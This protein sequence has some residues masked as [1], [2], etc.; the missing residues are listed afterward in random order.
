VIIK[1]DR[2]GGA[3]QLVDHLLNRDTNE[4][5]Q[6]REIENYPAQQLD[7]QNLR[8]ALRLMEVQGNA[9]GRKRTLYH[10]IIA[11]QQGETLNAKQMK[12]A[13][14]TL[15]DNLGLSGH[16]RVIIEHRK[17]G[18]QHF[19]VV[20]NIVNPATGKLARLQ[21]TRKIQWNTARQLEQ[22]LG[23][24]PVIAR[25][26]A[27]RQW[28]HQRGK[29]SGIDPLKVRKEI[30][31]ICRASKTGSEFVAALDH[32]GYVLT[33]GKN[34][35]YVLVDRAGDIH[36][37]M[38]RIEGAKLKDLRQKFPDLRDIRLPFL[39]AT[40]KNV[41]SG[42][43]GGKSHS[44]FTK[45]KQ[46]QAFRGAARGSLSRNSQA[47]GD[48]FLN[49]YRNRG[50]AGI[51]A[52]G[53]ITNNAIRYK[54][55]VFRTDASPSTGSKPTNRHPLTG[56][57]RKKRLNKNAAAAGGKNILPKISKSP[58]LA[59]AHAAQWQELSARYAARRLGA[60]NE[61]DEATRDAILAAIDRQEVAEQAAL[62]AK[63]ED[64]TN[65]DI[66]SQIQD[67]ARKMTTH[68]LFTP[69]P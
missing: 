8:N 20:F 51:P 41:R 63:Q 67:A 10:A 19:H 69:K 5:I 45:G 1:G 15:A 25:G 49:K 46:R 48:T 68:R 38:R 9:K 30:T 55:R 64:E 29:R 47:A 13:V 12:I 56:G 65:A 17:S 40:I 37:L 2:R 21:W 58:T 14:D 35:S 32:A 31:A 60:M 7:N 18:R 3:G 61:P 66:N 53:F 26:R 52:N 42:S 28:E 62:A 50:R 57:S 39:A 23:L 4:D 44:V 59:A 24:K 22:E 43:T 34:G 11:P 36:G 6:I 33:K 54:P 16:Q 27:S